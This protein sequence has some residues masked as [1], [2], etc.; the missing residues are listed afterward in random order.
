MA[1]V[2][3]SLA[4]PA[5]CPPARQQPRLGGDRAKIDPAPP[6]HASRHTLTLSPLEHE[7]EHGHGLALAHDRGTQRARCDES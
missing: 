3:T 4:G 5:L 2:R 1:R 7:L 6:P